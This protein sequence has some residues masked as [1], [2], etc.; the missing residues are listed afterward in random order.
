MTTTLII[1]EKPSVARAIAD[2]LPGTAQ[3]GQ[4]YITVGDTIVTWC[5]GHI[6]ENSPPEAY[7]PGWKKWRLDTL[8]FPVT[9]WKIQPKESTKDQLKIIGQLLKKCDCAV[10]GGDPDREGLMLVNE[11]LEYFKYKG[12]AK[13]LLLNSTD[14]ESVKKALSA[15]QPNGKFDNLHEAAKCRSRSDWLLGLS[16]TRAATLCLVDFGQG[17]VSIGRVQTPTLYLVVSRDLEIANFKPKEFY[18]LSATVETSAGP[19]AFAHAPKDDENRIFDRS[20]AQQIADSLTGQQIN[21]TVK[22]TAKKSAPPKPYTL[23]TFT[24]DACKSFGWTAVKCL[25]VLQKLYDPENGLTTYPRTSCEYLKSEQAGDALRV[26]AAALTVFGAEFQSITALL[27]PR[28]SIYDSSKVT[29]HHGIIP[30]TKRPPAGLDGDLM[31]GYSLVARRFL[32]SIAPDYLADETILAFSHAGREFAIKGEVPQNV[33]QSWRIFSLS[34][35]KASETLPTLANGV[36]CSVEGCEVTAG[37]TTPPKRYDEGGLIADMS[38]V[39]KF[40]TDEKIKARLKETSGIGT[41]ATRAEVLETLKA[42]GYIEAKGKEIIS[43]TRGREFIAVLPEH[44]KSPVTTALWEESLE[45]V[46][47]GTETPAAFMARAVSFVTKRVAEIA[48]LKGKVKLSGTAKAS[49]T[50]TARK[51]QP[52]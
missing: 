14:T 44:L 26:A 23:L 47:A 41:A 9:D 16:L 17:V 36:L 43:T 12:P 10:N 37:K 5:V 22:N 18:N 1:A 29:E 48:A 46:A 35:K 31:K 13:R 33:S 49:P 19:V 32:M 24:Q 27:A 28:D 34:P 50:A 30:T 7:D 2:A 25:E 39:A 8:P 45:A 3:R 15:M 38:A 21:L 40:V 52:A 11:V 4:G 6:L 20:T 42:R 51:P